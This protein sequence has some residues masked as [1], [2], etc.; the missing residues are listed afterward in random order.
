MSTTTRHGQVM[1]LTKPTVAIAG[2]SL[3]SLIEVTEHLYKYTL[4]PEK[5]TSATVTITVPANTVVHYTFGPQHPSMKVD[6]ISCFKYT[7]PLT[8]TNNKSTNGT[9]LYITA[10]KD[11]A[12]DGVAE[13]ND[14]SACVT[15]TFFVVP[16]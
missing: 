3:G 11:T 6:N 2:A 13:Y 12:A 10:F 15:C 5:T 1:T 16:A 4:I 14:Q 8:F 9:T 7:T